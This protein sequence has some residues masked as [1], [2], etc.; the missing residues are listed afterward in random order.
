MPVQLARLSSRWRN[1]HSTC[2]RFD[3]RSESQG[4]IPQHFILLDNRGDATVDSRRLG[5][6]KFIDYR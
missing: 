4:R 3:G 2:E 5:A 1:N 6:S